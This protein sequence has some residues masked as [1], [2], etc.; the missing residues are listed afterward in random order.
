[1]SDASPGVLNPLLAKMAAGDLTVG[2]IVRLVRG[3]EI[4][5]IAKTAGF[6]C[7]LLDQ[8]HNS[9]SLETISQ[10]CIASNLAGVTP[11]VRVVDAGHA[12]IT[13]ALECGA[14]GIIVPQIESAKDA[15][16]AIQAAKF[17]PLGHRSIAPCLPHLNFRPTPATEAMPSINSLTMV[18]V[19]IESLAALEAVEEIAAVEG[20]DMLLVG[21]N[22]MCNALG[23][24]GEFDHPKLRAAFQHVADACRT[25]GIHLGVGGLGPRPD[26][27]EEMTSL[28]ARYATAGADVTFF[29]N[30]AIA[31]AR[32]FK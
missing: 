31:Q 26:L 25:N 5:A 30:A 24:P 2:M 32:K 12:S 27:V 6:D 11:L 10:I 23:L 8:E 15:A 4:F 16:T 19:M 17:P 21:A 7:L 29:T 28:G 9:F 18:V 1:M 22:D 3:V 20:V 13:R 14:M